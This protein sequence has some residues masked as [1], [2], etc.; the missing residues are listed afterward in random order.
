MIIYD[1]LSIL[2]YQVSTTYCDGLDRCI[3]YCILFVFKL[4]LLCFSVATEFSVN[5]DLYINNSVKN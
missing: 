2:Q 3:L 5:K 1:I 4:A